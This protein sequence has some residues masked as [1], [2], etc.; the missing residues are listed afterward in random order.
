MYPGKVHALSSEGTLK[1]TNTGSG[2]HSTVAISMDGTIYSSGLL[3]KAINP[4]GETKWELDIGSTAGYS[5]LSIS[6]EG[7]V[8]AGN[9][10]GYLIAVNS[11]GGALANTPWPKQG[12]NIRNTNSSKE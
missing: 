5:S 9:D 11:D 10:S 2:S 1:W 4:N 12:R 3:F 8:Y 6:S 7:T